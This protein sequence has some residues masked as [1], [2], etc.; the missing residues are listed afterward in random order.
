MPIFPTNSKHSGEPAHEASPIRIYRHLIGRVL[1]RMPSP[2]YECIRL[3]AG[4]SSNQETSLEMRC[5][6]RADIQTY[7]RG[8]DVTLLRIQLAADEAGP[9]ARF[10]VSATHVGTNSAS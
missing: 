10:S 4:D 6:S 8:N 9:D 3:T 1:R 7:P 5:S 2:I